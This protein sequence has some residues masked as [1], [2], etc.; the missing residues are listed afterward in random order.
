MNASTPAAGDTASLIDLGHRY[1]L[2][3]YKQREVVLERGQGARLWDS[4]G[5][6][7]VDFAAG[8]AVC[9]LGH[10]DPDLHAALVEQAGKLWHTS[11]VFFSEPPLRLAEE[12]VVASRFA[13]R[14]FLCNSGAEA[15]EAAI[16]LVRK[17]AAAQGRAPRERVIV[18]FRGSFHG[19][20]L[21][22]VTATA[23]PKYQDGYEPL[24]AGFRYVDFN[25]IVQLETAMAAGDVAAV[26][27]EP[28][29]GEG[30]VTPAAS[31]FLKQVRELCDRHGALLVLDEIQ[32]GMGRTGTLFAHWQDDVV[33]DI[34]TLAKALGGGFPVGAMLAGPKVAQAMGFGA[35]WLTGWPAYDP[36]VLRLLGVGGHERVAGFIHIGTPRQEVPE[37]ER[38]DPAALLT[39]LVLR[40]PA[41]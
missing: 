33:P 34:V 22:A 35:N 10:N 25:D 27:L 39:D 2:P 19:R 28:V 37:R 32:A 23:Q 15:N 18:T 1:F 9:S 38:P 6:E 7:Y 14:V 20:T 21:A 31:G 26:M 8:I 41:P 16:K 24:P 4:A 17:W 36:E 29:Q 5:R 12:L 30:G 11:N 3:V 13:E 40:A